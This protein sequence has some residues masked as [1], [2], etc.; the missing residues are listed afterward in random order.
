MSNTLP[1][2]L[3]IGSCTIR[4]DANSR[5]CLNDLHQAAGGEDR[6][7]PAFWLRSD[8]TKALIEEIRKPLIVSDL[9]KSGTDRI[10]D[11]EPVVISKGFKAKQGTFVVRELVYGYAMWI[12]PRFHLQVIRAF[13]ALHRAPAAPLPLPSPAVADPITPA[14]RSA[15]NRRAHAL[16]LVAYEHLVERLTAMAR[17]RAMAFPD[18]NLAAWAA[19]ASDRPGYWYPAGLVRPMRNNRDDKING[20][21]WFN[22]INSPLG[23]LLRALKADGHDVDGAL[24]QFHAMRGLLRTHKVMAETAQS[25]L[26][27]ALETSMTWTPDLPGK[28]WA[29]RDW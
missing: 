2:S 3:S 24:I 15:I 1:M 27:N 12:S 26:R 9:Q 11:L 20:H 7:Q 28:L 10:N 5:F 21:A 23:D 29:M 8:Q 13:D 4:Q 6:H 16:S 25:L 19:G 14:V 22:Q 17:S 18:A